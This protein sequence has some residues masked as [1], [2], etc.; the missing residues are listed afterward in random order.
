MR[1]LYT[2]LKKACDKKQNL[3]ASP[4]YVPDTREYVA[5]NG[6]VLFIVPEESAPPEWDRPPVRAFIGR[7]GKAIDGIYPRMNHEQVKERALRN[8]FF[9]TAREGERHMFTEK[10]EGVNIGCENVWV[11]SKYWESA[12]SCPY[13]SGRPTLGI[14]KDGKGSVALMFNGGCLAFIMPLRVS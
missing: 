11:Q 6:H 4:W 3:Y 5:T 8:C 7:D 12:S 2:W 14:P 9:Q 10:I 13:N 1:N